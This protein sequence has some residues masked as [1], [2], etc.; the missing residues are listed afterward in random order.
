MSFL[1]N[2]LSDPKLPLLAHQCVVD[3]HRVSFL[4][5]LRFLSNSTTPPDSPAS[6]PPSL[7]NQ[8]AHLRSPPRWP[9]AMEWFHLRQPL[10]SLVDLV[11]SGFR[12]ESPPC[13][14]LP[15]HRA[16]S[17]PYNWHSVSVRSRHES[18]LRIEHCRYHAPRH[19]EF[20]RPPASD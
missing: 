4:L 11:V 1:L 16:D 3:G 17:S 5:S 18:L 20:V 19:H 15:G 14:A 9:L 8:I 13:A 7:S 10:C 6:D 12:R 2:I